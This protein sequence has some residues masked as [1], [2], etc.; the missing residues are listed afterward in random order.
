VHASIRATADGGGF[1]TL[2]FQHHKQIRSV[3]IL[4]DTYAEALTWNPIASELAQGLARRGIPVVYGRFQGVPDRFYD[5]ENGRIV[6]L[7]DLED[8]TAWLSAVDFQRWQG[9]HYRDD[10]F[11][12]EALTHWPMMAWIELREPRAWDESSALPAH[13]G[14]SVYPASSEGLLQ[15]LRRFMTEQSSRGVLLNNPA[16]WR[17][18]PAREPS[19]PL[20]V[21]VERLLGDALLWAQD[22]AMMLPPLSLGLADALRRAFHSRLPPE[23]LER[24]YALPGTTWN[25]SGLQFTQ[26]VL[27]VLRR[28]FVVRRSE[29]QQ[30]AVLEFLLR[31][32]QRMEPEDEHSPAHLAWEW[33]P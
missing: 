33:R 23:R 15:V 16:T 3:L 25:T 11:T 13:V 2:M 8:Q 4:E 6:H 27:A 17:G 5:L 14:L 18:M 12:L 20:A 10:R 1:P 19:V 21:H 28:G 29:A 32:I 22:C 9:L 26:P 31:Q 7:D 30:K 24:L